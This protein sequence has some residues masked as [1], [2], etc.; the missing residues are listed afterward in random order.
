M[1]RAAISPDRPGVRARRDN[2][3]A[4]PASARVRAGRLSAPRS[5]ACRFSQAGAVL[6]TGMVLLLVMTLFGVSAVQTTML[7]ER[8]AGN[9]HQSGMALQ[10]AE[11]AIQ[12]ALSRIEASQIPPDN[13]TADDRARCARAL[14]PAASGFRLAGCSRL[15]EVLAAWAGDAVDAEADIPYSA[16]SRTPLPDVSLQPRAYLEMRYVPSL[17]PQAAAGGAG[18][19]YITVTAVGFGRSERARAVLQSTVDRVLRP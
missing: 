2:P 11:A 15:K 17:D 6:I 1:V 19:Y 9:L 14:L 4:S 12:A 16:I 5:C 3:A 18:N 7:Q 13:D 8:I 10:S